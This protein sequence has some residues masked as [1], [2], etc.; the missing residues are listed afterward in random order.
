[1]M[2]G[3]DDDDNQKKKKIIKQIKLQIKQIIKLKKLLILNLF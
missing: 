3:I 2:I 1:M